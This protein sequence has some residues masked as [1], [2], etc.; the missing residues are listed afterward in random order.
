M[1]RTVKNMLVACAGFHLSQ[2]NVIWEGKAT[3]HYPKMQNCYEQIS[4]KDIILS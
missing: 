4:N 2:R 3:C 1:V